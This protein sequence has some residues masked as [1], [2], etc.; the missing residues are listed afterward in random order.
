M[1]I[2][3]GKIKKA[4]FSVLPIIIVTIIISIL[5]AKPDM[6][7]LFRF[8]LGTL[9]MVIG[10]TL[11]LIGIDLSVIPMGEQISEVLTK[12]N[13]LDF[14]YCPIWLFKACN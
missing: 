3:F 7:F 10:M 11:F 2:V 5:L 9:L 8:L 4:I 12:S 14:S 1:Q 13:K 6:D